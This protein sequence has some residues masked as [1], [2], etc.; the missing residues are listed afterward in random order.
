MQ[1]LFLE[2]LFGWL[3]T[4]LGL[5]YHGA[6]IK[7]KGYQSELVVR[8]NVA[9]GKVSG[10]FLRFAEQLSTIPLFGKVEP[11]ELVAI[12]F[13]ASEKSASS[14]TVERKAATPFQENKYYCRAPLPTT[15][16]LALLK[17]FEAVMAD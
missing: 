2:D 1:T 4:D 13:G 8:S 3:K 11:Q 17:E 12:Y 9:L 16:H 15:Q 7:Q 14:F 5:N 10:K 6:L